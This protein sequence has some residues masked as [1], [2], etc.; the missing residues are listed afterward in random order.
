V[1]LKLARAAD[2][3]AP[4]A[5]PPGAR[6]SF[7]VSNEWYLDSAISHGKVSSVIRPEVDKNWFA[8]NGAWRL[9]T[10][11]GH[12]EVVAVGSP[13]TLRAAEYGPP[14]DSEHGRA[15]R[16]GVAPLVGTLSLH[17][18]ALKR[19]LLHA[20]EGG[21]PLA[22]RLFETISQL[23]H[24]IVSPRLDAAMWRALST[25]PDVRYLGRVTDRAGRAGEAVAFTEQSGAREVLIISQNGRLLGFED[26][27]LFGAEGLHLTAY[28]AVVGYVTFLDQHWTKTA[29]GSGR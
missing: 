29:N 8:P 25:Q 22:I 21:A 17:P 16:N 4:L 26:L 11:Y 3:R 14:V 24:Q 13:K 7:V 9:L 18:A 28:P 10:H 2:H 20:D 15:G 6:V 23:H 27:I 1:L 12:P 19:E 5:Q